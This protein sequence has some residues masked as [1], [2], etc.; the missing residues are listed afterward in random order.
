MRLEG[1]DSLLKPV[2][3]LLRP[4]KTCQ[5]RHTVGCW[6]HMGSADLSSTPD[7]IF[8]C[9]SWPN[10]LIY[11]QIC[12][13]INLYKFILFQNN[14]LI[15]LVIQKFCLGIF[16]CFGTKN[17]YWT[18]TMV[19]LLVARAT[20]NIWRHIYIYIYRWTLAVARFAAAAAS[21]CILS[22]C[23][24]LSATSRPACSFLAEEPS[25]PLLQRRWKHRPQ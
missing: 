23:L 4:A 10:K 7:F 14:F 21:S 22:S 17:S 6:G 9:L 25:P 16:F 15:V 19:W 2:R 3:Q 8:W 11:N 18:C 24:S 20:P 1:S 13:I 5:G 12:S